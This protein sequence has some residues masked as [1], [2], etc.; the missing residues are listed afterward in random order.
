MYLRARDKKGPALPL[1]SQKRNTITTWVKIVDNNHFALFDTIS[2]RTFMSRDLFDKI[3][4]AANGELIQHA[5]THAAEKFAQRDHV[6]IVWSQ[7]YQHSLT[8]YF[9]HQGIRKTYLSIL[10]HYCCP[11]M[12]KDIKRYINECETCLRC[13]PDNSPPQGPAFPPKFIEYCDID[14]RDISLSRNE[15]EVRL[16][17]SSI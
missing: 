12:L 11:G 9:K 1:P 3:K 2:N 4:K 16:Q 17:A 7:Y 15:Q 6:C 5:V 14:S 8:Q 10:N 13:K